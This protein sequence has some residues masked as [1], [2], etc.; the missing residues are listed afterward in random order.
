MEIADNDV[1]DALWPTDLEGGRAPKPLARAVATLC[2]GRKAGAMYCQR[3]GYDA[4]STW[5]VLALVGPALVEVRGIGDD[6]WAS[7]A[8]ARWES[9]EPA[10]AVELARCVRHPRGGR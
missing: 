2:G 5:R 4:A 9:T 7:R 8:N 3:D 6:L 10:E 1:L